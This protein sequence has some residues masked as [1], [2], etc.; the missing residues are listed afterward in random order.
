MRIKRGHAYAVLTGDIVASRTLPPATR[1]QLPKV[2]QRCSATIARQFAAAGPVGIDLYRGD[3]WQLLLQQPAAALR[4][5]T[6]IRA[7][8]RMSL[9][10]GAADTRVSIGV[11]G[12]DFLPGDEV[13]HGDGPAYRLSGAGLEELDRRCRM[14]VQIVD[15][16]DPLLAALIATTDALITAWTPSQARAVVGA[17]SGHTQGHIAEQWKPAPISQQAVAQHLERARW[18]AVDPALRA[19]EETLM[20]AQA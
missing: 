12:I 10:R 16:S 17:L 11:G 20:P 7:T 3:G 1:R 8:L 13:S 19:F 15:R 18:Y 4:V 6:L 9:D 14:L 2:M 5:A